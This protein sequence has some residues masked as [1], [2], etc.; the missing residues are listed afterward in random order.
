MIQIHRLESFYWV[1]SSGGYARAVRAMPYP[2]TEPALHQ[3]VRKL[4][5]EIGAPLLERLGKDRM[6]P[7]PAGIELLRFCAPF[8]EQLPAALRAIR[9]GQHGASISIRAEIL[10][11]RRLLPRW[12]VRLRAKRPDARIELTEI[13]RPELAA[14][15]TGACDVLVAHLPELPEDIAAL[16]VARLRAWMV[17]PATHALATRKSPP[18]KALDGESFVAYRETHVGH[19]LQ[20]R[21]LAE[22]GLRPGRVLSAGSAETILGFV[23]AGLGWS[24]V[25]LLEPDGPRIPGVVGLPLSEREARYP[26]YAA[27]RKDAPAN[28][29]LDALLETAPRP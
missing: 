6:A 9:S 20:M 27:W 21:A 28:A 13:D 1:A 12:L 23:E 22:R 15:R 17:L 3:Q 8:F 29:L 2:I 14:L 18:W 24:L 11:L 5:H 19:A 7:T 4:E 25:P 26:V 10:I 16:E